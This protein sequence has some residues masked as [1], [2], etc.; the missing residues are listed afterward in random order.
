LFGA[1]IGGVGYAVAI[2]IRAATGEA[3]ACLAWAG[4]AG[5]GCAITILVVV[6]KHFNLDGGLAAL[7]AGVEGAHGELVWAG[8]GGL[9]GGQ[10]R[11]GV[12]STGD[13]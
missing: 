1:G 9:P 8:G 13:A 10:E 5:I 7:M 4:I 12:Q 11:K 2:R 6:L 3:V